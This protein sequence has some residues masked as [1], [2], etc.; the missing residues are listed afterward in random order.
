M[1]VTTF[2]RARRPENKEQ[3]SDDL[4]A[5]ARRLALRSGVRAVTLTDIATEA[6]VHVSGVRRYFESRQEIFLR[7][8]AEGWVDWAT[9]VSGV[10]AGAG[11]ATTLSRT[12][13]ARPLFCDLLAHVQLSLER[14]VSPQAVRDFKLTAMAALEELTTALARADPRLDPPA[15]R[16]VIAAVTALAGSLWQTSHPSETLIELYADHPHL[17][18]TP[19]EFEPRLTR[20]VEALLRGVA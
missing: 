20:L 11:L 3:R 6:G 1:I 18:H 5:A 9:A 8:A 19:A 15:A 7:L 2:Q 13:A 12:L 4:L 10:P 17:S 16:D 14:E